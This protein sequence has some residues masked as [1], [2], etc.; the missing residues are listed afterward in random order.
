MAHTS[1][2][3]H[4]MRA[5]WSPRPGF[6]LILGRAG[7]GYRQKVSDS[8]SR[9]N[10]SENIMIIAGD[11]RVTDASG[12]AAAAGHVQAGTDERVAVLPQSV[13]CPCRRVSET[14]TDARGARTTGDATVMWSLLAAELSNSSSD[15]LSLYK[16]RR[17][18][19]FL[20]RC[21]HH[22]PLLLMSAFRTTLRCGP[23]ALLEALWWS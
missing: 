12:I 8:Q 21:G 17:R 14:Q 18:K 9:I 3:A 1:A 5:F 20:H 13:C 10:A 7:C 6:S 22:A 11:S 23:G 4:T 19:L 16:P 15:C 2:R